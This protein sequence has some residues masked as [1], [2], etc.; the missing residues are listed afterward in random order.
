M[1][2]KIDIKS[3][4]QKELIALME[5][6]GEKAFRAKQIYQWIHEKLAAGY[7]DMSNLSKDLREKLQTE[8]DFVKLNIVQV[9]ESAIDGTRKYLFELPDG[10]VV[11]SV[12]MKYHH[13]NSVC[14]SSQ[15]GC[16]QGCGTPPQASA[17]VCK[18]HQILSADPAHLA[19]SSAG[20]SGSHRAT[21]HC[22]Q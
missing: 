16:R 15:V 19:R 4:N 1:S 9:Q 5:E 13:G 10:N 12:W 2:E 14:I 18:L 3:L 7:E 8:E 21:A 20:L 22:P 11:E 6:M 17:A